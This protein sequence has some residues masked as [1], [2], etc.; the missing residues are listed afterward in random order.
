M[1]AICNRH[2]IQSKTECLMISAP[3]D[4]DTRP[5]H[6]SAKVIKDRPTSTHCCQDRVNV[7]ANKMVACMRKEVK[8]EDS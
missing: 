5:P 6:T 2:I 7:S 8:P 4:L 3:V 1:I